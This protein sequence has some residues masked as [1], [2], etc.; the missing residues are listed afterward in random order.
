M[1]IRDRLDGH[2][3][4]GVG[5]L[6]L[7]LRHARAERHNVI[8][9]DCVQI[10]WYNARYKP[11]GKVRFRLAARGDNPVRIAAVQ[12]HS[13]PGIVQAGQP[14]DES[15]RHIRLVHNTKRRYCD[16]ILREGLVPG[17]HSSSR[18]TIMCTMSAHGQGSGSRQGP[19]YDA[20]IVINASRSM[21][22][23]KIK[24]VR[25]PD[26][27]VTTTMVVPPGNIQRIT[28]RRTGAVLYSAYTW[29]KDNLETLDLDWA[30]YEQCRNPVCQS[31]WRP[32]TVRC[33]HCN[34]H[35][36]L[37][38]ELDA[39]LMHMAHE[40]TLADW[41]VSAEAHGLSTSGP[42][43]RA[44]GRPRTPWDHYHLDIRESVAKNRRSKKAGYKLSLIH[45]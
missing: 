44:D 42:K 36:R 5:T 23:D 24:W 45:I 27:A 21:A 26:G 10:F 2:G 9:M 1:C 8:V 19:E 17:G 29:G 7:Y 20:C 3:T 13:I 31:A 30:A 12:G 25:T 39:L 34:A 38:E 22:V 43:P 40:A 28:C 35:L 37:S 6:A 14:L 11:E 32:G 15:I 41:R 4:E 33:F 18:N 16:S